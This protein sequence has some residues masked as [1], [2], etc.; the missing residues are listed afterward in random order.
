MPRKTRM[1]GVPE[2]KI[3]PR[4]NLDGLKGYGK[5]AARVSTIMNQM[6]QNNLARA[7]QEQ[8][9]MEKVHYNMTTSNQVPLFDDNKDIQTKVELLITS[10]KKPEKKFNNNPPKKEV[11]KSNNLLESEGFRGKTGGGVNFQDDVINES[12]STVGGAF[13]LRGLGRIH[14]SRLNSMIGAELRE[15]TQSATSQ[16]KAHEQ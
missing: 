7:M 2:L 8:K 12:V 1:R 14:D 4:L 9:E 10:K 6:A 15:Q 5:A 16:M 13:G 3:D 11:P